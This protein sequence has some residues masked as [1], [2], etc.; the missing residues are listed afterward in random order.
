MTVESL[1]LLSPLL[2]IGI[3]AVIVMLAASFWKSPAPAVGFSIVAIALA[4]AAVMSLAGH[5]GASVTRLLLINGYSLYYMGLVLVCSLGVALLSIGYF[6]RRDHGAAEFCL[7]LLLST[8][9]AMVIASSNHFASMF[10]GL[11][12]Q[13]AALY[14]LIAFARFAPA[15]IEA[16]IKYLVPSTVASSFIVF[17]MAL[18]YADTGAM[19]FGG[20]ASLGQGCALSLVTTVGLL[21]IVSGLAFKLAL[22]PFHLWTPDVYQGAP[23]PAT[24]IVATVAKAGVAA[25]FMRLFAPFIVHGGNALTIA[26]WTLAITSMFAGNLLALKQDNVKRIIAYS[27]IAHMGYVFV[28]FLAGAPLGTAAATYYITAYAATVLCALAAI[29]LLSGEKDVEAIS[30]FRGLALHRPWTAFLFTTA[31]LSLAGIPFTIGFMGK[32][33]V[34]SA[35]VQSRMWPLTLSLAASSAIGLYYY[36]RIV[37]AL[38]QQPTSAISKDSSSAIVLGKGIRLSFAGFLVLGTAGLLLICFGI[39][40]GPLLNFMAWMIGS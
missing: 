21:M 35:S 29:T 12:L 27:S 20:M 37:V 15:S 34:V 7:F 28:A 14:P 40:P 13:S 9:G 30:D 36:L 25:L 6:A 31:L 38:Y 1:A 19:D 11:E 22:A 16:G 26:L 24:A 10:L 5:P 39:Y 32:F 8:L 3:A 23:A 2:I 4:L 18:V 33:Y 17:G